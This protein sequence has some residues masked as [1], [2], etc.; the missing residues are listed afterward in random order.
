[1]RIRK[2]FVNDDDV[3]NTIFKAAEEYLSYFK[4]L[5]SKRAQYDRLYRYLNSDMLLLQHTNKTRYNRE[6]RKMLY[7]DFINIAE[8][9][10]ISIKDLLQKCDISVPWP[11]YE[12]EELAENLAKLD[13]DDRLLLFNLIDELKQR[14]LFEED[15][16]RPTRRV[17]KVFEYKICKKDKNDDKA[18][19]DYM[20]KS[21]KSR[22]RSGVSVPL[23]IRHLV[24]SSQY[25]HISLHWIFYARPGQP[26]Y[27]YE[28]Y[29]DDILARF[30]F[31]SDDN[32]NI[33]LRVIRNMRNINDFSAR[34]ARDVSAGMPQ[35]VP[36]GRD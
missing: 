14:E 15:D 32:K 13:V 12:Y 21:W 19:P 4:P 5:P 6:H 26:C 11:D 30:G 28:P 9:M 8:R 10:E 20:I 16:N 1:M 22:N 29:V 17:M 36:H 24:K 27:S 25:F 3:E 18:V 33:F 35:E 23:S 31:L 2:E 7:D 34:N